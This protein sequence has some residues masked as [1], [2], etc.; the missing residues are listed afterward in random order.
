[1]LGEAS[2]IPNAITHS[3]IMFAPQQLRSLN[4][5]GLWRL[6]AWRGHPQKHFRTPIPHAVV[7]EAT[8]DTDANDTGPYI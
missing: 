5:S 8:Q 6:Q 2:Q 7:M 1:M 3:C 4:Y